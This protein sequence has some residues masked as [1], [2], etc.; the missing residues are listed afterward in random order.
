MQKFKIEIEVENDAFKAR[1]EIEIA[2]ILRNLAHA[3][4]IEGAFFDRPGGVLK[5]KPWKL[6][7]TNGNT[8]GKAEEVIEA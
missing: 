7:D 4:C 2:R 3:I 5:G 6:K 1:P 8:V